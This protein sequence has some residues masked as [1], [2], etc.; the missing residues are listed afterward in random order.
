MKQHDRNHGHS[1]NRDEI[2]AFGRFTD[3]IKQNPERYKAGFASSLPFEDDFFDV[4]YSINS[5]L[6]YV[7]V[8]SAVL[9]RSVSE[10]IRV[11]KAGG[12]I[13]LCPFKGGPVPDQPDPRI[14][15][16]RDESHAQL[17]NFLRRNGQ[18]DFGIS[19]VEGSGEKLLTIT[20]NS[21]SVQ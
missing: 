2:S 18:V 17:L 11:T 12:R 1:V 13:I 16:L 4:V 9:L 21:H 8:D 15:R 19:E 7:D 3:S 6:G 5:V 20:K 10:F 14:G